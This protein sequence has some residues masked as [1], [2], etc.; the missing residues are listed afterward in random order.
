MIFVFHVS[1]HWRVHVI[2]SHR[3]ELKLEDIEYFDIGTPTTS[4]NL[5]CSSF[6]RIISLKRI[7]IESNA[8]LYI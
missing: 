5:R 8:Y 4:S 3:S 7:F 2:V 1:A 6:P